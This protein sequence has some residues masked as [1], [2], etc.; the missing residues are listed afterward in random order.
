[1]C[2]LILG[3]LRKQGWDRA[4]ARHLRYG[5]KLFGICGGFKMLG[6]TI[7]DPL[8]IEGQI[9]ESKGLAY[10]PMNT[11]LK[12]DKTLKNVTGT[13]TLQGLSVEVSGYEIHAGVSCFGLSDKNDL[14]ITSLIEIDGVKQGA[15]SEDRQIAGCYLHGIF[16]SANGLALLTSW[17]GMELDNAQNYHE[18]EE[19]AI[20]L[21][22]DNCQEY[23]EI[24]KI[25]ALINNWY[26]FGDE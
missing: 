8:G 9:G 5:G 24:D 14:N 17:L 6:E 23:L 7:C 1:M 25:T 19:V 10:F 12:V 16:D 26:N 21:L 11:E 4:L 2:A 13:M 3:F 22:A 15:V 18:L 20:N